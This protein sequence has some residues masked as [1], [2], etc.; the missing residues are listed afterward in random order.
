MERRSFLK[1]AVSGT[2]S[3]SALFAAGR[4]AIGAPTEGKLKDPLSLVTHPVSKRNLPALTTGVITP[5]FTPA[6]EGGRLDTKGL[7]NYVDWLAEDPNISGLFVR[8]GVGAMY[9]YT[10]DEVRQAIDTAVEALAG[11]KYILFGTFGIYDGD[12]DHRPDPERFTDESLEFSQYAKDRGADGI[13]LVMPWMLLP[14]AGESP[15][16]LVCSY[17][18]SVCEKVEV[19]CIVYNPGEVPHPWRLYPHTIPH[20]LEIPNLIGAKISTNDLAWFSR[21]EMAASDSTFAVIPG[22][23]LVLL[24]ALV[25]GSHG[26]IGGGCNVYPG[27]LNAVYQNFL[28]GDYLAAREAQVDANKAFNYLDYSPSSAFGLAYLRQK[29]LDIQPWDKFGIP[30]LSGAGFTERSEPLDDLVNKYAQDAL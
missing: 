3:S 15:T 5:V 11:R 21:V 9:S 27:I 10:A 24:Q 29:G 28:Q 16:D 18:R 20:L 12:R 19:P 23:E 26:I 25:M 6:K 7:A 1:S 30:H 13:V 22:S 4:G 2:L 14:K 8:C 17:L